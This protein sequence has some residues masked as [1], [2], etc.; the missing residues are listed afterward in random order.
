MGFIVG[1]DGIKA[2][3][4]KIQAI[5]EWPM[6]KTVDDARSFHGLAMYYRRFIHGFSM[7]ATP[8]MDYLKK[9]KFK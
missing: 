1:A 3:E 6:P 7:I 9:R 4:S 5:R 2:I 8:I